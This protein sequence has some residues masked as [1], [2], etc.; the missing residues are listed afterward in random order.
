MENII[1]VVDIRRELENLL[2]EAEDTW[3]HKTQVQLEL[4]LQADGKL[5]LIAYPYKEQ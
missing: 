3:G 2:D 4:D 5:Y 1:K